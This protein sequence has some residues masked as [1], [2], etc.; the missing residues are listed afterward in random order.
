MLEDGRNSVTH[1]EVLEAFGRAS[2]WRCTCRPGAPPPDPR[3]LQ[4]AAAPAPAG[5]HL[6]RAPRA[7]RGSGPDP[8]VAAHA[9]RLGFAARHRG[10]AWSQSPYPTD[11]AYADDAARRRSAAVTDLRRERAGRPAAA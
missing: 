6:R 2:S 4:R 3:A 7:L 5:P 10:S 9:K 8:A 1:Y 11:L